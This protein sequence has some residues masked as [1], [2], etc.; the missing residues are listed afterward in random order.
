MRF[1]RCARRSNRHESRMGNLLSCSGVHDRGR[2]AF[3]CGG[4]FHRRRLTHGLPC[5]RSARTDPRGASLDRKL[6]PGKLGELGTGGRSVRINHNSLAV[7]RH[8][9]V[10]VDYWIV[11]PVGLTR[12]PRWERPSGK[13]DSIGLKSRSHPGIL[14]SDIRLLIHPRLTMARRYVR[15][16]E[17]LHFLSP[18]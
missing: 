1:R 13:V 5:T 17:S 2:I 10:T 9:A 11:G 12:L 4:R 8:T 15:Q 14:N 18:R 7:A 16:T 3:R 6:Q